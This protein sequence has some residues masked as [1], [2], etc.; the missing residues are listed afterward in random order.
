MK[1]L[2]ALALALLLAAAPARSDFAF[3]ADAPNDRSALPDPPSGYIYISLAD[4]LRLQDLLDRMSVA[5]KEQDREIRRL[6]ELAV[7]GGCT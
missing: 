6:K 1:Q 7:R 2:A 5:L 4:V 3:A